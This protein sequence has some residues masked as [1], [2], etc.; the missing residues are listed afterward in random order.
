GLLTL[1]GLLPECAHFA[2]RQNSEAARRTDHARICPRL[3]SRLSSSQSPLKTAANFHVVSLP[4]NAQ[5]VP[6]EIG[7]P[8]YYSLSL[9]ETEV[10]GAGLLFRQF[11][12]EEVF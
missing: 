10:W 2:R 11:F 9:N 6:L 3:Q 4:R 7:L 1:F 5:K 12:P 8:Y